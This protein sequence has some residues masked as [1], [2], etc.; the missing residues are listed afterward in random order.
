MLDEIIRVIDACK[1]ALNRTHENLQSGQREMSRVVSAIGDIDAL[2]D[3]G[4]TPPVATEV[5]LEQLKADA[6]SLTSRLD[7]LRLDVKEA[8]RGTGGS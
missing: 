4:N 5:D 7:Q 3:R 8:K 2:L 6:E 1:A